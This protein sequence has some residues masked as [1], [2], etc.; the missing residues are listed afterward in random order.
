[1]TPN[2][3]PNYKPTKDCTY[4]TV[5]GSFNNC[6]MIGFAEKKRYSDEM[7][8]V[9]RLYYTASVRICPYWYKLVNM[10][11]LIQKTQPQWDAMLLNY[12][13]N[14]THHKNTQLATE[15]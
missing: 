13:Q 8:I 15:K 10:V 9:I 4:W 11:P 7:K 14:P 5:L 2:K 1:M 6:N 12:Y 3:Q